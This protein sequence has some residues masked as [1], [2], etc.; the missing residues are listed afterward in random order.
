MVVAVDCHFERYSYHYAVPKRAIG[1]V[2]EWR[3]FHEAACRNVSKDGYTEMR[4][5]IVGHASAAEV[6][7]AAIRSGF[8]FPLARGGA[9]HKVICD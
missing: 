3:S 5:R 6:R 2:L 4:A 8:N 7:K 1:G 9:W